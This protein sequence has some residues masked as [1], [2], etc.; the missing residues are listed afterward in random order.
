MIE[1]VVALDYDLKFPIGKDP[2]PAWMLGAQRNHHR[3]ARD[4]QR[5]DDL[6]N[7]LDFLEGY[8]F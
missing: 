6:E 7:A 2:D 3:F 8:R 5:F 4:A 1:I